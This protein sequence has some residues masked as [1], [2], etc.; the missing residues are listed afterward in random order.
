MGKEKSLSLTEGNIWKGLAIFILPIIGSSLVQQLYTTVDAVI[1]GQFVGKTGLAAIDSVGTLFKFPINFL[2]GMSAGATIIVSKYYGRKEE[3]ELDCSIHSA[4]TIALVLGIA[5]S[6]IGV[7]FSPQLLRLMQVPDDIYEMTLVY[8]RI[9]F[10]GLWSVTLYNM[11]SG[12]IRA[13]GDSRSPFYI[14]IVCALINVA[15]DYILVGLMNMGAA[16]AAI[17]TIGAQAVSAVLAMMI[18]A[19]KHTHCHDHIWEIRYCPEHFPMTV[20]TGLPLAFQSILFPVANSI[21][22][23]NVNTMGTDCIAAWAVCGKLDLLI[24]LVADA[25]SPALSTYVAQN[26]GADKKDRVSKGVFIGAGA[27][28]ACIALISLILFFFSGPLGSLFVSAE[29]AAAL[30]PYVVRFMSMMC[31]FYVFY[32][33]A[34]AFS[35]A[36]CGLG[37]T[38]R[39]MI[40]TLLCTCGLRVAAILFILPKYRS[41]ETIV[42]IY[43]ASWIVTGVTFT[44]LFL[45]KRGKL[46]AVRKDEQIR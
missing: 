16:G 10:A 21:V 26:I 44:I 31:P 43:I 38:L 14:L 27:S 42:W 4:Y 29:D 20:K 12:I 2:N 3:E 23:A 15:G 19:N 41:M 22:Q 1:V 32:A 28:A 8:V 34:E 36:V 45:A 24:W 37:D 33:L 13:F 40:I 6:L 18:L 11:I 30:R 25:M 7:V 17:A 46:M 39:P 5:C 35:G 9:Y